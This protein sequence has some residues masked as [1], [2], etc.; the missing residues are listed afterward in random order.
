VTIDDDEKWLRDFFKHAKE[1]MLPK[2]KGSALS[3]VIA[4]EP[5][6][7]LCLEVGAAVLYDKPI[8]VVLPKGRAVGANLKRI[9]SVIVEGEIGD[10]DFSQRLQDA[11]KAVTDNDIRA[12]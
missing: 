9:A 10:P 6:I 4:A 8:V 2:M 5:D 11:L 1:E 12:K 3:V 7:K